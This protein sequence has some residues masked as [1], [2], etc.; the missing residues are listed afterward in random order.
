MAA[1][2][3]LAWVFV[4]AETLRVLA[5]GNSFSRDAIEQ[6]L[7]ELGEADGVEIVVGNLYIGGCD[8]DRH[9]RNMKSDAPAY[10]YRK[11]E[12]DGNRIGKDKVTIAEALADEPWDYISLQQVS[13]KAGN[14]ATYEGVFPELLSLVKAKA[15]KKAKYMMH[16]TWA[17]AKDSNHGA[18]PDYGKDQDS[19][20]R[21][22]AKTVDRVAKENKIKKI[23]PAGAAIQNARTTFVGDNLNR[24]GYHLEENLGRYTAA[25]AW[26]EALTGRNVV[27][28]AYAP[29]GMNADL[30]LVAQRAAHEAVNNPLAVTDLSE[31]Q[32]MGMIYKDASVPDEIRVEDLLRRMTME[33]KVM[34][35]NQYTLGRNNNANNVGEE[36]LD[37]PAEIGSLIYF[38]T[39]P[40]LRNTM[41]KKA[42]EE[43]RLGIPVLFGFDAIHGFRTIYPIGLAQACSWN[44]GLVQKA[45]GMSAAETKA[46]GIDWTFSPMIDV[47]RDPRWGRVSEGYG[48]DPYANGVFADAS[49]RGYQGKNLREPGKIAACLKHYVGYGASEAGRDYVY[50]EISPQTLWD[51][52]L[53]PY[54]RGVQAGAATLM[55]AFNDISGVPASANRYT[56]TEVLKEKWGHDGFIVSDWGAIEQLK[57]QGR[58]ADKRAAA[59]AAFNAGL[60]MDMMSHAYDRH[61]AELVESGAISMEQIDE[62]VRRVLRVKMRLGLFE[63]PYTPALD[64][65]STFLT[66]ANKDLARKMAEESMVLLKNDGKLLPMKGAKKIAVIGPLAQNRWDLLGNWLGHGKDTDVKTI[67]EGIKEK[68]GDAEVIYSQGSALHGDDRSMLADAVKAA[69][70]ADIVVLCL[71]ERLTWSGENAVRSD[72]SLPKIQEELAQA[73]AATGKPIALVLVNG[74]PLDLT[75]L[76]PLSH[77]ILEAWQPGTEGANAIANI[78]SGEASPSGKLAITFPRATG[79][80]PIYYNRRKSGRHHQGFYQ[81]IPSTPLYEFGHG[82]SYTN[83]EYSDIAASDTVISRNGKLSLEVTVKNAGEVDGAEPALWYVSDP[84]CRITRPEKELKHIEK[85]LIPAG[86]SRTYRFDVNLMR[87]FGFVDDKGNR[88]ME[89]GEYFVEV[90]PRKV[91]IS[92]KD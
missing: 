1:L 14:Y 86:E 92:V 48:E 10:Y 22:V 72:I 66:A 5:I 18:F 19:M 64:R 38:D 51:T 37:I 13:G 41:Q 36:V 34:Q 30:K 83:F 68:F 12:A 70:D 78:L 57:N 69:Q 35:L 25:C 52:Y 79:Q 17:Y 9:L 45:C 62:A 75:R 24:D 84:Y 21:M 89:E 23:A 82:L 81:D 53:L 88:F 39:V 31:M 58:V 16:Q 54:Q 15:P 20:F 87:D 2:F 71:G 50:T 11:V 56:M 44:K 6:N 59:E 67:Y 32:P 29:E 63:N 73:I 27:G 49:V 43:S 28:N 91:R 47:A 3:S 4:Q 7:H 33:E 42:M 40:A 46:A 26:Y 85:Q 8:L 80:I 55:S 76:E 74:R 65:E 77:A 60:E 61:L 90:G